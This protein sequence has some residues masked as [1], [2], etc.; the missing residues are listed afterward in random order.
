MHRLDIEL[1]SAD[2]ADVVQLAEATG[3]TTYDTCY[4]WF[5]RLLD[6]ELLT[7]DRK[8]AAVASK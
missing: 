5:A 1:A 2:L 7:L 3:L 4:L 6:C 8:L